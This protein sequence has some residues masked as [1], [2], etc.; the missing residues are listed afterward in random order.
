ML[1]P[2]L[3]L[4]QRNDIPAMIGPLEIVYLS[5]IVL[6]LAGR[7]NVYVK[8]GLP[9]WSAIIPVYAFVMLLRIIDRPA[10]WTVLSIITCTAP[11]VWIVV[12]IDLARSFGK[13]TLF[14]IGLAFLPFIFFPILGFSKTP[15]LGRP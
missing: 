4:A 14:G 1:Q 15:Y 2:A 5:L 3:I 6:F 10:W 8:A 9:G 13:G 12:C 7:W 11:F